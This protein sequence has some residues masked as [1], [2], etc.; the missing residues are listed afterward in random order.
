[1]SSAAEAGATSPLA[2]HLAEL[3]AIKM[4][5]LAAKQERDEVGYWL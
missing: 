3:G 2:R 1:M 5:L 4:A